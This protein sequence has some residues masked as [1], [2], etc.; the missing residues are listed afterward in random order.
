MRKYQKAKCEVFLDGRSAKCERIWQL[1]LSSSDRT[2]GNA[3]NMFIVLVIILSLFI[4]F[5]VPKPLRQSI[6]QGANKK[7]FI[8]IPWA[9]ELQTLTWRKKDQRMRAQFSRTGRLTAVDQNMQ[10]HKDLYHKLH[11]L[12]DHPTILPQLRDLMLS[13][14]AAA[15]IDAQSQSE[16]GILAIESFDPDLLRE[17]CQ[18]K[19][20]LITIRWEQYI[21]RR[22]AGAPREM[23]KDE[24]H[25]KWWLK[26]IAPVKYVDGAWLGHI[27]K[28][29]TPFALRPVSKNAW[30]ILSEELGDGDLSKNH[31]HVYRELMKQIDSGLPDGDSPEFVSPQCGLDAPQVWKAAVGQ[32]LISLFPYEFFPEILGFNMHFEMLTWDTMRAIKEL[33]EL[34]LNDYYFLLHVS[35][36]NADSGH[37]AMAMEVVVQYIRYIQETEGTSAARVAWK[38]VQ[39]GFLLSENLTSSPGDLSHGVDYADNVSFTKEES[40]IVKVFKAKAAVAHRLHCGS[41]VKIRG[42]TLVEW[43]EPQAFESRKWQKEFL[44]ALAETKPWI[45]KG[46]SERS[47]LVIELCWDG[48]MFGSFTQ[49]EVGALRRWIDSLAEATPDVSAYWSFIGREGSMSGLDLPAQDI[50]VSYPIFPSVTTADLQQP[51][52]FMTLDFDFTITSSLQPSKFLPIWFAQQSILEGLITVPFRTS[53][54]DTSAIVG[55]L[56]TQYGFAPEGPG[57]AGMDEIRRIDCVDIVHMGLEMTQRAGL[58]QPRNLKDVLDN[59]NSEAAIRILQLSARPIR[60]RATLLG[61]AWAFVH[62]HE[63]LAISTDTDI[64]STE[65]KGLLKDMACRERLGLQTCLEVLRKDRAQYTQF[66]TGFGMVRSEM[67]NI[68]A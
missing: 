28:I 6:R 49:A 34:K 1:D 50:A 3:V 54:P 40:E 5:L 17:F 65:T 33:K 30:Q 26:Q 8:T 59:A 42:K 45:H 67:E 22:Q 68:C 55:V 10:K 31:V 16:T 44:Q 52:S 4:S 36:D 58:P 46:N 37:T 63:A 20:H 66:C 53:N 7:W 18:A 2:I 61:M 35:I 47:K 13:F 12:E 43:L 39:I 15:I 48:K 38:R 60:N 57:V 51:N 41:K 29:T 24:D 64:L 11:H 9:R 25:A 23:F 62:L 19:D 27:H 21:L 32:L 56:R 14:L